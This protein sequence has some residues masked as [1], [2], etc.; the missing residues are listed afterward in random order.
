MSVNT[1]RDD[2]LEYTNEKAS[3]YIK[4]ELY[5]NQEEVEEEEEIP[6]DKFNI[7]YFVMML[8]G[9]G[10]LFPWNSFIAAPDYFVKNFF[11]ISHK[12]LDFCLQR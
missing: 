7:I 12:N 5:N 3:I 11:H 9:A 4:D 8:Q 2:D 10:V 6:V 1:H